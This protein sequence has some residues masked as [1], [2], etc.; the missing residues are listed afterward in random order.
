MV[1]NGLINHDTSFFNTWRGFPQPFFSSYSP[2]IGLFDRHFCSPLFT[3]SAP[4]PIQSISFNVRLLSV[5]LSPPGNPL[6]VGLE[7]G[8]VKERIANLGFGK[9]S[10]TTKKCALK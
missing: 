7:T 9:V 5:S 6:P 8:L 1:I 3:E 4:R 10:A 2:Q